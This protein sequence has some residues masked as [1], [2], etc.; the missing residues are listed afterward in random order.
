MQYN[1]ANKEFNKLFAYMS[2]ER[3]CTDVFEAFLDY[4]IMYFKHDACLEDFDELKQKWGADNMDRFKQMFYL[5][6]TMAGYDGVGFYDPL[7][8]L[9]MELVAGS[10]QKYKGQFF[11]PQPI[12]DLISMM[13]YGGKLENWKRINDPAC[14]SGRTLLS[15]AK[16]NRNLLFYAADID[17]FCCKM[18][19][20]NM[21]SNSLTCEIAWMNSISMEHFKTWH[22]GV[23]P[24]EHEG[25]IMKRPYWVEVS[26]ED[27][28]QLSMW[29]QR[30]KE[31]ATGQPKVKEKQPEVLV[32]GKNNQISLF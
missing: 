6:G 7:G 27:T 23:Y 12:C 5:Y 2:R 13:S 4:S 24:Y 8:D 20:L 9:F 29:E 26:K 32:V 17:I 15:I 18:T 22:T 25:K 19:M 21:L 11:T 31:K 14:G 1:E 10:S 30:K 28:F 16:L 3:T